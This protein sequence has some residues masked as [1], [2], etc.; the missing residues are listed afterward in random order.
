MGILKSLSY[1]AVTRTSSATPEQ[2]RRDKLIKH[3]QEQCSMAQSDATGSAFSVK[4]RRWV[5]N[6]DGQK[7]LVEFDKRLKRWW[8]KA[9]DGKLVLVVRWGSKPMEFE[10]GKAGIVVEDL[11]V[12]INTITRLIAAVEAGEMDAIIANMNKQRPVAKKRA[13]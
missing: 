1:T 12:L 13:A 7:A 9:T 3:L 2:H 10:R 11:N 8:N 4:K 5:T 6:D